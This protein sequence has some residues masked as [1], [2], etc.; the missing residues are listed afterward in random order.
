[1]GDG[2][3][4]IGT[5]N[6]N[7]TLDVKSNTSANG[8]L[9]VA[10]N[11]SGISS[12]LMPLQNTG[13]MLVGWNWSSGG[14]E[15]DLISN[16]GAGSN[17]G[18]GFYD[19]ANNGTLTQLMTMQGN[20]NVGIGT[21]NPTN[22][23]TLQKIGATVTAPAVDFRSTLPLGG[24]YDNLDYNG[25][26]IYSQFDGGLYSLARLTLAYPTGVGTFADGLT[27]RNGNV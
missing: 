17:G 20:G 24:V 15:N 10:G 14:G 9:V 13:K 16:R 6:P 1:M 2:N 19:Y 23:L 26:R 25:G 27:L 3:V 11:L 7:F 8:G 22:V 12:F 21:T 4:G 18:F 5:P